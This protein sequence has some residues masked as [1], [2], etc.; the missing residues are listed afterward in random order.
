M[1]KTCK[2]CGVEKEVC[3]FTPS[4]VKLNHGICRKCMGNKNKGAYVYAAVPAERQYGD[5][6][7]GKGDR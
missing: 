5:M 4:Q 2:R 7:F 3:L 6:R 1:T